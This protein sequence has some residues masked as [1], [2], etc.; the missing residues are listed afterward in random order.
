MS[1]RSPEDHEGS[2][3]Y[4]HQLQAP[5]SRFSSQVE[6][7]REDTRGSVATALLSFAAI[8]TFFALAGRAC[9]KAEKQD[10]PGKI[11]KENPASEKSATPPKNTDAQNIDAAVWEKIKP[12]LV[13]LTFEKKN[14]ESLIV[15]GVIYQP[16]ILMVATE[17]VPSLNDGSWSLA[18]IAQGHKSLWSMGRG[19]SFQMRTTSENP[20][21]TF[22]FMDSLKSESEE[23]G[24]EKTLNTTTPPASE[25]LV[26]LVPGCA[27]AIME[28]PVSDD[29]QK[30]TFRIKTNGF[31]PEK[32]SPVFDREGNMIGFTTKV[33][34]GFAEMATFPKDDRRNSEG[35][36]YLEG[37]GD[38]G[39]DKPETDL[40]YL[41]PE[42]PK[43]A[44]DF[45]LP[46]GPPIDDGKMEAPET[47]NSK[48][49]QKKTMQGEGHRKHGVQK[50]HAS[51]RNAQ[52]EQQKVEEKMIR[53]T[54][55]RI[56]A[57]RE[58]QKKEIADRAAREAKAYS[59]YTAR[60][61]A[62]QK[63]QQEA[64]RKRQGNPGGTEG[65]GGIGRYRGPEGKMKMPLKKGK[66]M[67]D[68]KGGN[69]L[70]K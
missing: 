23:D 20:G 4:H 41:V 51:N 8:A 37:D 16:G 50:P 46:P 18:E 32:G 10:P 3:R 49:G 58:R 14:G 5:E 70:G 28:G 29:P 53:E 26:L 21:I 6:R 7:D 17:V 27:A 11:A 34:R 60:I 62:M 44:P 43:R 65:Y 57:E 64:W 13:S 59:D 35:K 38:D 2:G 63:A 22:I 61:E 25:S 42:E 66:G 1:I 68:A 31:Q 33:G 47:A 56:L 67:I 9:E 52:R 40:S 39:S 30:N 54:E 19:G 55:K 12:Y 45:Q 36:G 48:S 15:P 69:A 24:K